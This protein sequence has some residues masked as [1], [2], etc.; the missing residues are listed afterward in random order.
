MWSETLLAEQIRYIDRTGAEVGSRIRLIPALAR[1]VDTYFRIER[2]ALCCFYG[3]SCK[4]LIEV[5]VE[6]TFVSSFSK[7]S[8]N[9]SFTSKK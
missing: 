4:K 9:T 1:R 6:R 3:C 7:Y 2:E 8:K 5:F